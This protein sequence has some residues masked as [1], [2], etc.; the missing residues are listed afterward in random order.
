MSELI[1]VHE[2][3]MALTGHPGPAVLDARWQLGAR[4]SYQSYVD[5]DVP[6]ARWVDLDAD[7]CAPPGLRGRHPLPDAAALSKTLRR[8]GIA[9]SQ[10]VVVYD[11]RDSTAAARGW[12]VLRWAGLRD[13]RVLDGGFAAW[14]AAGFAVEGGVSTA[15]VP[16][17]PAPVRTGSLPQLD[18]D[19]A[20]KLAAR[21]G[22]LDARARPR[23]LG[24]LEPIDPVAGHIPGAHNLPTTGNVDD[25]GHFLDS[26]AL[27]DRFATVLADAEAM[28]GVYCG[29]G[30]TA[31]HT[32]LAMKLAG[33]DA[34]LYAGSWS[35]WITNPSRPVATGD[36]S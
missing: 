19:Q 25:S 16:A 21:G 10:P 6:G 18:A 36:G 17:D 20:G 3:S 31:A 29:S 5:L 22:L 15:A 23:Y 9:R 2:L 4:S 28:P 26:K 32:V 13:V 1:D 7:L 24:E 27:R 33:I 8:L 30:V 35:E 14:M 34:A 12:W 11:S